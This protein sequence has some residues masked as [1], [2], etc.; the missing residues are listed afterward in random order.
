MNLY[1]RM[2]M[3]YWQA[4]H[5]D[6]IT[7]DEL[8]N[9]LKLRVLPND[10]DISLHVNNGRFLTLCDLSRFD[11]FIRT[12]LLAV[13]KQRKWVP[14]IAYHDMQYKASLKLFQAYSLSMKI[15]DFDGKYFY[16]EHTFVKDDKIMANGN[17]HAVIRGS[18][19][20]IPPQDVF[21]AVRE[22]QNHS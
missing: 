12:G 6:M 19:G 17:S 14:L 9:E 22:W 4:K 16:S 21:N 18:K 3:I 1:L 15:K 11:L 10:L 7:L 13:M 8:S 2:L 5:S 20:V